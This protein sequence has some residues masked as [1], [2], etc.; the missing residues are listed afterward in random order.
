MPATR[1][2]SVSAAAG[3]VRTRRPSRRIVTVSARSRTSRRKCETSTT[4][5]AGRGE[6]A[7][8]LVELLGLGA[9]ER[10]G[11]LVE[12]EQLRVAGEGAQDLDLLLAAPGAGRRP[13]RPRAGRSRSASARRPKRARESA[14]VD[15]PGTPRLDAQEDVLRRR[16]GA[17][18]AR[19]PG[20]RAR[21]RDA[22]ASRG[23]EN[24]TRVARAGAARPRRARS[25]PATILPSVDLPAPFSPTS[26]WTE[27]ARMSSETPSR[28]L[29]LP[30]AL[31]IP[32]HSRWMAPEPSGSIRHGSAGPLRA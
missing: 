30:K 26:A 9:G 32:R 20:P 25:T 11:R 3:A 24:E 15:D 23:D 28:A 2:A 19:A 29:V 17:G 4:V 14:R 1:L 31:P 16:S 6:A 5:R 7:D 22:S 18:R 12:D 8:D 21:C 13:G 27:P 10:R